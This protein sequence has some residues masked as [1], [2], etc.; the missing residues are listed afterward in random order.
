MRRGYFDSHLPWSSLAHSGFFEPS[1]RGL[2]LGFL[3]RGSLFGP[4]DLGYK[5][6]PANIW[7][8]DERRLLCFKYRWQID[9]RRCVWI[10]FEVE[11]SGVRRSHVQQCVSSEGAH[12]QVRQ[13]TRPVPAGK[14]SYTLSAAADSSRDLLEWVTWI[15]LSN[16]WTAAEGDRHAFTSNW[17]PLV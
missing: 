13:C 12:R 8:H 2:D 11:W 1:L 14:H 6:F 4:Y 10:W 7:S 17:M 15:F 5:Y 9:G 3:F 16:A